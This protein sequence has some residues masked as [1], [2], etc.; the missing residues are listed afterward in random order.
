MTWEPWSARSLVIC[1]RACFRLTTMISSKLRIIPATRRFPPTVITGERLD[2]RT[3]NCGAQTRCHFSHF[4]TD[5]RLQTDV[6]E[7]SCLVWKNA[8]S[9]LTESVLYWCWA[10][11]EI[12]RKMRKRTCHDALT[13]IASKQ[14]MRERTIRCANERFLV[15]TNEY[16]LLASLFYHL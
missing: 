8:I 14:R 11:S 12:W 9:N 3:Y 4:N 6:Q 2:A 1:S 13:Y 7:S 5:F 10:A 15:P 16:C